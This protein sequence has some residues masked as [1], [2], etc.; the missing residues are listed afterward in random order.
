MTLPPLANT[1]RHR[2]AVHTS[3][4]RQKPANRTPEVDHDD[5]LEMAE[6]GAGE[7]HGPNRARSLPPIPCIEESTGATAQGPLPWIEGREQE[8][9]HTTST[10]SGFPKGL[11]ERHRGPALLKAT[12]RR[13]TARHGRILPRSAP[14]FGN[15]EGFKRHC[16][17]TEAHPLKKPF[18]EYSRDFFC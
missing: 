5:R 11:N 8:A 2:R 14:H 18:C 9:R 4:A 6:R 10:I 16:D 17:L 1:S 13:P 15:W 3:R 7:A 12:T